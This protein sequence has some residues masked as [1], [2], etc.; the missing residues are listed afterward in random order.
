MPYFWLFG[1]LVDLI[2][3]VDR[4]VRFGCFRLAKTIP[5]IDK[6]AMM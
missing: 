5:S 4:D 6:F 3:R 2:L 1:C